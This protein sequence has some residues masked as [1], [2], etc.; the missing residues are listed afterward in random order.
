MQPIFM[1]FWN[2]CLLRTGPEQM[3]TAGI[4]VALVVAANLVL[5]TLTALSAPMEPT[6]LQAASIPVV[7]A[8]VLAGASWLVLRAKELAHRF[9]ATFTA[10]MGADTIMTAL[11]WPLLIMAS[12]SP[13]GPSTGFD[14]VLI[15]AQLALVFWWV[16]VAGFVFARALS[17]RMPQGVAIAVFVILASLM[18]TGAVVPLAPPDA[19]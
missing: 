17:V 11:S 13:D 5:S 19:P 9:T 10:L 8:A 3:P 18:V 12:P 4:F 6:F 16:T 14:W 1:L 2:L 7:A 15:L